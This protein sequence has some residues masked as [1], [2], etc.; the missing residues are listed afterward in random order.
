MLYPLNALIA[1]QQERLSEWT[2][3][4]KGGIRYALYNVNLPEQERAAGPS[5][6]VRDR[7]TLRADP[8]PILVT[9]ITMLEYM[10]AREED[11]PI[12]HQS[13]G[14]LRWIVL[15][16]AH[17]YVG[18]AAAEITLLLRRVCESFG[19]R[20]TDVR[21]VATSAT[22]GAG[23][24][25]AEQ[26]KQ[27]LCDVS[28]AAPEN[29]HVIEGARRWP[30]LPAVQPT[31]SLAGIDLD[32]LSDEGLY[33]RLA[34]MQPVHDLVRT[35]RQGPVSWSRFSTFAKAVEAEPATLARSV[36]RARKDGE[37]ILPLR[38]HAFMRAASGIWGCLNASCGG[39]RAKDWPLGA[40][41]R[42]QSDA[43]PWCKAAALP[44]HNC[45]RCGTPYLRALELSD[46]RLR[47]M[48]PNNGGDEFAVEAERDGLLDGDDD[49]DDADDD[50]V[51][52]GAEQPVAARQVLLSLDPATGSTPLFVDPMEGRVLDVRAESSL[53]LF[54]DEPSLCPCPKCQDEGRSGQSS[55][56]RPF[57]FGAP[58]T[59][60]NA[61]PVI[62]EAVEPDQPGEGPPPPFQGRRILTF[63]DSRQGTA[64]LSAKMQSESERSF[65][66]SF[67]YHSVQ[68]AARANAAS[69]EA[70]EIRDR[71]ST[72]MAIPNPPPPVAQLIKDDQRKLEA[73][74][75]STG[76][77]WTELAGSLAARPEVLD[78][79]KDV[80]EPRGMGDPQQLAELLLVREFLRRSPNANQLET[81]GL[82]GLRFDD[83]DRQ[84]AAPTEFRTPPS[85]GGDAWDG[86]QA[87]KDFLHVALTTVARARSAV[88][89]NLPNGMAHW[90]APKARP[91][92]IKGPDA[93]RVREPGVIHWP[94]SW[95]AKGGRPP[96]AVMLLCQLLDLDPGSKEDRE[97]ID[98]IFRQAWLVL[99]PLLEGG[100]LN[101]RKARV[102][103]VKEAWRCPVTRR[104]LDIAP[105]GISM[106]GAD[107]LGRPPVRCTRLAM[108]VH[109][110]PFVRDELD[111]PRR[112]EVETWLKQDA[113][114]DEARGV[115]IWSSLHDR[116]AL[117]EQYA[118]SAEHS[119]QQSSGVLREL[120]KRFRRGDVNVLNCST[121]MEMGVDIG[122]VS[123]VMMNNVPPSIANYR[124]R[125]GRAGRRG[126]PLALGLTFA[127]ERPLDQEAFRNPEKYLQNEVRAPRVALD[128]RPLVQRHVNAL[129]LG[130][131]LKVQGVDDRMKM[132]VGAFFS[133]SDD[134]PCN[135]FLAWLNGQDA[136]AELGPAVA[137][138]L[139]RTVLN[140]YGGVWRD[141]A[142]KVMEIRDIFREEER[143]LQQAAADEE[144]GP[145]SQR[146]V[147]FQLQRLRD[148]FL[149]RTL[150]EQGFLPGHGFPTGVVQFVNKRP[151]KTSDGD[152]KPR[153]E[154]RF[155]KEDFPSR[156]LDIALR[157]YAPGAEVV[158]DGLVYRSA[159]VTLNWKRPATADALRDVQSIRRRFVCEACGVSE[160]VRISEH[161]SPTCPS[162]GADGFGLKHER[163]LRPAGFSVDFRE[164]PHDEVE[165]VDFVVLPDPQMSASG[166]PWLALGDPE[167]GR[168][169][170]SR[171]G[172]VY[173]SN[174]GPF[175]YAVCLHCGRT[176]AETEE[177]PGG[178]TPL[179]R[180]MQDHKPLAGKPDPKTGFCEGNFKPFAVQ[181]GLA[182]GYEIQTDV[183]ELQPRALRDRGIA[184][185][186]AVAMREGLAQL[187]GIESDEIGYVVARR[188]DSWGQGTY[189]IYLNDK[190]AGGAGYSSEAP[191]LLQ[192]V[193][194]KAQTILDCA[195]PACEHACSSCVLV[196]DSQGHSEELDRIATLAWLEQR[197]A[198]YATV[199]AEDSFAPNA[200]YADALLPAVARQVRL[201][202]KQ[203]ELWLKDWPQE[204]RRVDGTSLLLNARDW[205]ARA[206][207]L[208]IV[209]PK[210]LL[211]R[212]G[213]AE[214]HLLRDAALKLDARL[215]EGEAP[216]VGEAT[217]VASTAETMW[218]S[219]DAELAV[220]GR[221]YGSVSTE[222][223]I[224]APRVGGVGTGAMIEI[225]LD[226]LLPSSEVG[227]R[228]IKREM[229]GPIETFGQRFALLIKVLL[230]GLGAWSD[231]SIVSLVYEDRYLGS[232]LQMKLALDA[233]SALAA[234]P[235]APPVQVIL[236]TRRPANQRAPWQ[237]SHDWE[238]GEVWSRTVKRYGQL[239]GLDITIEPEGA[240]AR[241]MALEFSDGR[242]A[243]LWPEYGFG[244]WM[245]GPTERPRFPF[246]RT[247]NEQADHLVQLKRLLLRCRGST[248]LFARRD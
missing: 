50:E 26:L 156:A 33:Q 159:G 136:A 39:P 131:W 20:A 183:F 48:H 96:R 82:A 66:R 214:K 24:R 106:Y 38:V 123:T 25:S 191:R 84:A 9:N 241:A 10:L 143:A 217:L 113:L 62:L 27:F 124:Q 30:N 227:M 216:Q 40:I 198:G 189:S 208:R 182:L 170:A 87:W 169:R 146:S 54:A 103:A 166:E 173:Y 63:T 140:G 109:P 176:V 4:Y 36:S 178:V 206:V 223:L 229:D 94:S 119:A 71:L 69:R 137:R 75:S 55:E 88:S 180:G 224:E 125:V 22:I 29:V 46:G 162:C 207:G 152:G 100:R 239:R 67:V 225:P 160:F 221:D 246:E 192:E 105:A 47:G 248:M 163:V 168:Y 177:H 93:E 104:V 141:A 211:Q 12:L 188:L 52:E 99:R 76:L 110:Y 218:L 61:A 1:S 111:A 16:E 21:F 134:P 13:Q 194:R 127:K 68:G 238:D 233:M 232:P 43:C 31:G 164:H 196:G 53:S 243:T 120:E 147:G 237:M 184:L 154:N 28:G 78:W 150:A 138:L 108:P 230:G 79:M 242:K 32:G 244:A 45:T 7:R 202:A 190:G 97:T 135:R 145:A 74:E 220:L 14:K 226:S 234:K 126:Q 209:L 118:R 89:L 247:A 56:V 132:T 128:S 121:T 195:N 98:I 161:A 90:V 133:G 245:P 37:S 23:A 179:P 201:G 49:T 112:V 44:L 175:G 18:S 70:Q 81:M 181:R 5:E 215:Y 107:R 15:D 42:N 203:V 95:S 114:L 34:T 185:T 102:V 213:I 165:R 117:F 72:L 65:V 2:R 83:I 80:W 129:L 199:R 86:L 153:G 144:S 210:G 193:L 235:G 8:P 35:A 167:R 85:Q 222:G 64:R 73:L 148:E 92:T 130:H 17:S 116:I 158:V 204:D 139:E 149:L 219:R 172:T 151:P 58:F 236:R 240:H 3:P 212:T 91:K 6:Q 187:L 59:I 231:A 157:E 19:V 41:L 51:Q 142:D 101:L 155:R 11:A 228:E 205:S 115:G 174:S 122:S 171:T 197:F 77:P 57:L 60:P 186:L 200:V